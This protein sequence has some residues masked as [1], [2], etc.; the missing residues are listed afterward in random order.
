MYVFSI[1]E[2]IRSALKD[3]SHQFTFY[4]EINLKF[5]SGLRLYFNRIQ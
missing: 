2:S 1:V 4:F 3:N 5:G